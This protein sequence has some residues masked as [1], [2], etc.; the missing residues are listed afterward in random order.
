MMGGD[1]IKRVIF[2]WHTSKYQKVLSNKTSGNFV[3]NYQ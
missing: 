2:V 3:K 1:D